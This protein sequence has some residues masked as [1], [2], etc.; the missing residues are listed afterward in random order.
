MIPV[1]DEWPT[2]PTRLAEIRPRNLRERVGAFIARPLIRRYDFELSA[3][4]SRSDT[5]WENLVKLREAWNR[6]MR[7]T[8]PAPEKDPTIYREAA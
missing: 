1:R 4:T 6:H 8:C 7:G 2:R 3:E 5:G